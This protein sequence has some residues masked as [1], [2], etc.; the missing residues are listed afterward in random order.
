MPNFTLNQVR[1]LIN[2]GLS[3]QGSTF[4]PCYSSCWFSTTPNVYINGSTC[5][6]DYTDTYNTSDRTVLKR[7]FTNLPVGTQIYVSPIDYYDE[8]KNVRTNLGG[9]FSYSSTFNNTKTIVGTIVSGFTANQYNFYD[10]NNFATPLQYTMGYTGGATAA[11]YIKYSLANKQNVPFTNSGILGSAFN[12]EEYIEI[13]GSTLNSGKIKLYGLIKLKDNQELLYATGTLANENLFTS[14]TTL[15]HYIRGE[16]NVSIIEKPEGALGSFTIYD[17]NLVKQNCYENQNE[18]QAYLRT[19]SLGTAYYGYWLPCQNCSDF[20]ETSSYAL[21][22]NKTVYFTN[23]IYFYIT[24]LQTSATN[25]APYGVYTNRGFTSTPTAVSSV[26]FSSNGSNIKLDLSHPSLQG[27][28]VDLYT[29]ALL[30]QKVS[31]SYYRSGIPGFDQSYILL[32]NT[33]YL[34][35]QLYCSFV[36]PYNLSIPISI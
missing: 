26:A 20:V 3:V 15:K 23:S 35:K 30:T 34:P 21:S 36:G 29:D 25:T 24:Q 32:I 7:I 19:Q 22:G 8:L 13:S 6:I 1:S 4:D 2:T 18:Y 27:W 11:S 17:T 9:T 12:F 5:Y 16:S 10:K 33:Q 31:T 14:S 28:S